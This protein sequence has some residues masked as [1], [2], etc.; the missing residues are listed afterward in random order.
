MLLG[1]YRRCKLKKLDV[2][3]A[4]FVVNSKSRV[5]SRSCVFDFNTIRGF[6][7]SKKINI[8]IRVGLECKTFQLNKEK[9]SNL[10][11]TFHILLE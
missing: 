2:R 4:R 9:N 11:D 6:F 7:F 10:C 8:Q 5:I 1:R 3:L